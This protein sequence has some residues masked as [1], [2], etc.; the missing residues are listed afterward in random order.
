MSYST[1]IRLEIVDDHWHALESFFLETP[2]AVNLPLLLILLTGCRVEECLSVR[3]SDLTDDG[4]MIRGDK[5]SLDRCFPLPP[6]VHGRLR[7]QLTGCVDLGYSFSLGTSRASK[8]VALH[9][10]FKRACKE[11]CGTDTYTL[12][13]MRH[14]FAIRAFRKGMDIVL[15]GSFLGHV[16]LSSTMR[17]LHA[18]RSRQT[19]LRAPEIWEKI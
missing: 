17:Y 18:F 6:S 13:S 16:S 4:V 1:S 9:T 11:V 15:V 8:R 12:H 14:T 7:R 5:G 19:Q 2:R 3:E 10:A